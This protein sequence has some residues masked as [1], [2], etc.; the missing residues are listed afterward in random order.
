[1]N[2]GRR[3]PAR[4][5]AVTVSL[6]AVLWLVP[7]LGLVVTAL[8]P[9]D[10]IAASGW[11][12][13]PFATQTTTALRTAGAGVQGPGDTGFV[14]EGGLLSPR[15]RLQA[16]GLTARAPQAHAPG[17]SV[18]LSGGRALTVDAEG[19]YRL[20]APGPF[21]DP[22]GQRIFVTTATPPRLT[23]DN[24]TRVTGAEGLGRALA[25]T[26][27]VAIPATALP[28]LI[29]AFAAHALAGMRFAGRG[30][31]LAAIIGLMVV[32]PQLALIPLLSLHNALG[33][34]KGYGS[35]W[36]AHTGFGLPLAIFVLRSA[37][38]AVPRDILDAARLDGASE[39]RILWGIVLPLC[40]P[41]VAGFAALQF[42]WVWNDL[43]VATVFLG[44]TP[45]QQVLSG[46][47]RALMGARGGEWH[48]LAAAALVSLAVPVAVFAT[49]Q[50]PLR[51][52]LAAGAEPRC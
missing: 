40:L 39:L 24:L 25:N 45:G 43:L 13:A 35:V 6:M 15:A 8:R 22:R 51:R 46:H 30:L 41:A 16:W 23:L 9:A 5:A 2:R 49:L 19:R 18:A 42:L 7:V 34:G 38:A 48:I 37:M 31:V 27:A 36:L 50:R 29:A 44:N 10:Q 52:A 4:A 33:L 21:T 3:I 11:W 20:T 26:L 32:P 47:L 12:R 14:I 17:D 1:M 28:I